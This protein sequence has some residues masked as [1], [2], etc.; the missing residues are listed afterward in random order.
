MFTLSK[1]QY[2]AVLTSSQ[3]TAGQNQNTTKKLAIKL[4]EIGK[5]VLELD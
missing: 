3:H 4:P 5:N 1:P 2:R